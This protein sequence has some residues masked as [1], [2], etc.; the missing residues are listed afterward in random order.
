VTDAELLAR[1]HRPNLSF[2]TSAS[3]EQNTWNTNSRRFYVTVTNGFFLIFD[4]DPTTMKASLDTTR[5]AAWR[6]GVEFSYVNPDIMYGWTND[7]HPKMQQFDL[8]GQRTADLFDPAACVHMGSNDYGHAVS[9]SADD[10]RILGVFGPAQD[11][12]HYVVVYD[13]KLGCRWYDTQTG[14]IGGQWGPKGV[15]TMRDPFLIHNAR[16]SRSGEY[17]AIAGRGLV[18][19]QVGTLNVVQCQRDQHCGGHWTLGYSH[20]INQP[21]VDDD[22]NIFFRPMD[23]LV[24]VKPLVSPLPQPPEWGFDGHWSWNNNDR[25]DTAPLCGSTYAEEA[26]VNQVTRPWDGEVVCIRTDGKSSTVWRFA[27]TFTTARNGFWSTPRG[28]VSQDGRFFM[29]TSDWQNSLGMA[30][31][32]MHRTDVFIVELK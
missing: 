23:D 27:H 22:M 13:R 15:A 20:L 2:A 32:G 21:G 29:F 4:F 8:S 10:N 30:P 26:P 19:W 18:F 6:P 14:E 3:A 17:V 12:D 5:H 16:I 7:A 31:D 11:E 24:A 28:N 25:G 1:F 9:I